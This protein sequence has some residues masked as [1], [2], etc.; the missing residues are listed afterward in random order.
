MDHRVKSQIAQQAGNDVEKTS[1][2]EI[3]AD[4]AL[5]MAIALHLGLSIGLYFSSI[6]GSVCVIRSH[7][8]FTI[9]IQLPFG[10]LLVKLSA[11]LPAHHQG[12][13]NKNH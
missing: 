6:A 3:N 2:E 10:K 8:D 13:P 5:A 12:Y 7:G 11:G 9:T 4:R 1:L